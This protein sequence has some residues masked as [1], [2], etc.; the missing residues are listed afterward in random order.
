MRERDAVP[1]TLVE[2]GGLS[3]RARALNEALDACRTLSARD[4]GDGMFSQAADAGAVRAHV[5]ALVPDVDEATFTERMDRIERAARDVSRTENSDET[6]TEAYAEAARRVDVE[7]DDF[8]ADDPEP[9]GPYT[10]VYAFRAAVIEACEE[11][12][13][14][15]VSAL[16]R[17]QFAFGR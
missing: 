8:A 4:Q 11:S 12:V 5:R 10:D 2:S 14:D 1:L 9:G 15:D 13:F 6:D 16:V 3:P 7:L 17:A